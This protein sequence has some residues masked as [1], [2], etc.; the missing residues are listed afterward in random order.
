MAI[1]VFPSHETLGENNYKLNQNNEVYSLF[2]IY[3]E[4]F[5]ECYTNKTCFFDFY[6]Q[7]VSLAY[8]LKRRDFG[9]YDYE[10]LMG[11]A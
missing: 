3:A 10:V 4:E 11:G 9:F 1:C 7:N 6:I 2:Q 5:N 8:F